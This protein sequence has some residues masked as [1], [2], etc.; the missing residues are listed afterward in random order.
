[1]A[2]GCFGRSLYVKLH[3]NSPSYKCSISVINPAPEARLYC[4][5][6]VKTQYSRSQSH[7]RG[8]T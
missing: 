5:L 8:A 7:H 4:P 3:N 2:R 6:V 1:M